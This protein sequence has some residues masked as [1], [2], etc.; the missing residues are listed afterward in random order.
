MPK[1]VYDFIE[2]NRELTD[3]L[4]GKGANLAEMTRLGLPVPPGFTVT[5]VACRAYLADG[6]PPAGMF[7][8]VNRHLRGMEARL[9]KR[10]GDRHDPLLLA[11][12]S[13]A[14]FSMPGMMET[15]LDI[16]LTDTTVHG[17][18]AQSG[19][20]RFA[21]DSYRRLVQM[22][23]RT[24]FGVPDELF[25]A[26]L[27]TVKRTAGVTVDSALGAEDL[28]AL[29]EAYQKVFHQHT[30]R[31]FPQSPHEQLDLAIR[32]VFE[33]WNAERGAVPPA[34]TDPGRAGHRSERDGDGVRQPG[35]GLRHRGGV[36]PRPG[37]RGTRRVRRLPGQRSGRGRGVRGPQHGPVAG[38]GADR[39]AQLPPAD[40]DHGHPGA[41]LPRPV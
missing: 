37:D 33:S 19:D 31:D 13:G 6:T 40:D 29:V 21:W 26:E 30:G 5:T 23:G 10:L 8:E 11:V 2:G 7:D 12:R 27:E 17:L 1:F 36:H 3:L 41:P 39:P 16:G 9:G 20:D 28:R 14:R 34:G 15:V 32:A 25:T 38:S 24:V 22:F 4:G 18:A 35:P